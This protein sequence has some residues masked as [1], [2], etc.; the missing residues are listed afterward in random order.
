MPRV[1]C[2][3]F[4]KFQKKFKMFTKYFPEFYLMKFMFI[5]DNSVLSFVS[6]NAKIFFAWNF[7]FI[8]GVTKMWNIFINF[9]QFCHCCCHLILSLVPQFCDIYIAI[10]SNLWL[11]GILKPGKR[12]MVVAAYNSSGA[13]NEFWWFTEM[14]KMCFHNHIFFLLLMPFWGFL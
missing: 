10:S 11:K 14:A 4:G 13:G 9:P 3:R 6:C 1:S 7:F 2:A 5:A 8:L 12:A